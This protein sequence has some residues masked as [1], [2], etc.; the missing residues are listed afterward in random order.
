MRGHVGVSRHI[1]AEHSAEQEG[2]DAGVRS[3]CDAKRIPSDARGPCALRTRGLRPNKDYRHLFSPLLVV[4]K[5]V[6][7]L[8]L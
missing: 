6:C 2:P 7:K 4:R 5:C 1:P 3:S 8:V